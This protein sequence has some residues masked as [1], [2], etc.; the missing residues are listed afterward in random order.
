MVNPL[1]LNLPKTHENFYCISAVEHPPC[2]LLAPGFDHDLA[3]SNRL[4]GT[5]SF[6]DYWIWCGIYF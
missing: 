1:W 6:Q 4:A 5:T 2:T 3:L